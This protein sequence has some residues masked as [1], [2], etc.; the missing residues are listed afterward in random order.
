MLFGRL[1]LAVRRVDERAGFEIDIAQFGEDQDA[2]HREV[3]ECDDA[4]L[5]DGE[6]HDDVR[7][8]VV[9][10]GAHAIIVVEHAPA[11][12]LR[13]GGGEHLVELRHLDLG[14]FDEAVEAVLFDDG[15]R[16][17]PYGDVADHAGGAEFRTDGVD[18]EVVGRDRIG[19][20]ALLDDAEQFA[21]GRIDR[22][23]LLA[24]FHDDAVDVRRSV[25]ARD[26]VKRAG[27]NGHRGRGQKGA[28]RCKTSR[29]GHDGFLHKMNLPFSLG[30]VTQPHKIP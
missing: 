1:K 23:E 15:R 13:F 9:H 10:D 26:G 16:G 24:H 28:S 17:V 19:Q 4:G 6:R 29:N 18:V 20:I 14:F 25:V 3:G 12:Q 30:D 11:G 8:I 22:I 7:V 2:G 5:H 21:E 27:L